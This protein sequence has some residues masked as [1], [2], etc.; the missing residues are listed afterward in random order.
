MIQINDKEFILLTEYL[1]S[2]F[3]INLSKKR[4]LIESRLNNHL[5]KNGFDSYKTYLE[6]AF[7]DKTGQEISQIV[8]FLTTNYSYFMREWEHFRYFRDKVMPEMAE[9]IKDNDLRVWSAG[10]SDG[11]EPYSVA[12]ILKELKADNRA[13]IIATDIDREIIR[14]AQEGFY[15][16]NELKCLPENL[17]GK[18]F[19]KQ[20]NNFALSSDIK[21]MIEFRHHN[22]LTDIYPQ[23]VDLIICRNV[24][25]YFTEQAKNTLY[26]KFYNALKPGGYLLVGG[27]EPILNYRQMG[28]EHSLTSFYRRPLVEA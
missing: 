19:Q 21:K 2:N 8:N 5:I 25:I 4:T 14:K 6:F 10:C 24:V 28:F 9:L 27:T 23:D 16:P 7:N 15:A 20:D 17:L 26:E 3:G 1:K 22:L 18:Y 11:S 13:R 12:I